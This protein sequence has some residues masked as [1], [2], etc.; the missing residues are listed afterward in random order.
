MAS[1]TKIV[2]AML[3]AAVETHNKQQQLIELVTTE[4]PDPGDLQNSGNFYWKP[5][6]QH[7]PVISGWDVSSATTD[8]IEES[9]PYLLGTP[10]NDVVR[11]RADDMRDQ[12]YWERR[13]KEAGLKQAAYLNQS[14]ASAIAT[15][16]GI[17]YRS[18]VTSGWDFIGLAQAMM[19]ERQLYQEKR[20]FILNDRDNYKFGKDLAARQTLQGR[21]E[22]IWAQG[23]IAQNVCDFDVYTGSYLSSLAGGA[24]PATTVTA[25][26]SGK[27]EGGT[28]NATTG[29]VT[30]VDWRTLT[31]A[32]TASS[33]YN[34]GDKVT[35]SNGGTPVYALGLT[36]KSNTSQ[37]MTFTIVAKPTG[38][39]VTIFPKPIA[40]NDAGLSTLEKAY[41]NINTQILNTATMNRINIDTLAKTNIFFD[42]SAVTVTGGKIPANL[43][44]DFAGKKVVTATLANGLEMYL[45]YD[46]DILTGTF[47]FRLFVWW[48]IT[49]NNPSNCGVAISYT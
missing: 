15:Q 40:V 35:F 38:T 47:T 16:A 42:K 33:G 27:P 26:V 3:D 44:K 20:T 31:I 2:T 19:N 34:V 11:Q 46:G 8:I 10:S 14:I 1:T 17:A 24:D 39:S 23:Q 25:D 18:N 36:D 7:S 37:A 9:C 12:R 49:V 48:G 5:I 29:V 43:W 30:N 6:Q 22:T 41:A 32:V 28:V 4:N 21:P 45:L 13:G